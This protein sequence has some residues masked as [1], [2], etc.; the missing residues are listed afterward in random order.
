MILASSVLT[1]LCQLRQIEVS[2]LE[3]NTRQ[4]I[5]FQIHHSHKRSDHLLSDFCD[6]ELCREHPLFSSDEQALQ[7]L[8]YNDDIEICNPLGSRAKIHKMCK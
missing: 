4:C 6:G 7:V 3:S 8:L 1:I 2:H 5:T